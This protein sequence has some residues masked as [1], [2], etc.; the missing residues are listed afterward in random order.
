MRT[1]EKWKNVVGYV[2]LYQVSS[3][4]KIR[5][6]A[7]GK[8]T[9]IGRVLKPQLKP[10]GHLH[11][12]LT[13]NKKTTTYLIHRLMLEAFVGPCPLNMVSRHLDGNGT[14]NCLSNVIYGT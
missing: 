8:G 11:T 9:Y 3:R 7:R 13:K 12:R 5:R 2:G 10:D 1:K 6:I 4:G 14:N